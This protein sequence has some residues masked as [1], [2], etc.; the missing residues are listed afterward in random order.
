MRNSFSLI[1]LDGSEDTHFLWEIANDGI[2]IYASPSIIIGKSGT[3]QPRSLIS[4][5][6]EGLDE[7]TERRIRRFI[8]ENESGLNINKER[9]DV[10]VARGVLLLDQERSKRLVALL[11]DA[12]ATYSLQK[13]WY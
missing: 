13:L 4:Y 10:Y 11:D 3:L 2:V 6:F 12:G 9:R 1:I 7:S 5:S 8:Y